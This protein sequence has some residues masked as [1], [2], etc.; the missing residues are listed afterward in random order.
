MKYC[1]YLV[2]LLCLLGSTARAQT[3]EEL[4]SAAPLPARSDT[5][6]VNQLPPATAASKKQQAAADSARLTERLFGIRLTKP[7]KAALLATVAPGAGQIYNKRWWKLPLV[8]G[9][10][11]ALI[12]SEIHYQSRFS[13]YSRAFD[14]V[15][16]N[17][18]LIGNKEKLGNYAGLERT[19]AAIQSGIV[20]YRGYRD[21]FY[22]YTALA[23][24]VQILDALVD[25]HLKDFDVSDDLSL[26]WEPALLRVPGQATVFPTA[27]G[28]SFALR[29]K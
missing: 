4:P 17:P 14:Q 8:Y 13:E 10:L 25:A 16:I 15:T 26:H 7:G 1:C 9:G 6:R 20:F 5:T 11:G 3:P 27:P 21:I 28:V 18:A 23:Y 19:P 24:G 12:Y 2:A 29:V 22:L